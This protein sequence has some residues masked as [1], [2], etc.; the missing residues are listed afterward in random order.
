MPGQK[1]FIKNRRP[2][3]YT[4]KY[5]SLLAFKEYIITC[6][7]FHFASKNAF[8]MTCGCCWNDLLVELILVY[9]VCFRFVDKLL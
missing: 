5:S 8:S 9:V 7:C 2:G 3:F 4:D 1:S 6:H